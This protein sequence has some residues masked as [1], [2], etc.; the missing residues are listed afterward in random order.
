MDNV[1]FR[2]FSELGPIKISHKWYVWKVNEE[3][4]RIGD[5]TCQYKK[6]DLGYVYPPFSIVKKIRT[7]KF[8]DHAETVL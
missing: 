4:T 8:Q 7:G 6:Y 2:L 5:L 3:Y 1:R